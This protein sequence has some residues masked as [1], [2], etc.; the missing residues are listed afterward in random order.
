MVNCLKCC[1]KISKDKTTTVSW[2][3]SGDQSNSLI[4]WHMTS[5][6]KAKD[7]PGVSVLALAGYVILDKSLFLYLQFVIYWSVLGVS[8][9]I[10]VNFVIY[11]KS[12]RKL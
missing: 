10:H 1:K 7:L 8:E 2:N 11:V 3:F 12:L 6:K 9:I 4:C 5:L